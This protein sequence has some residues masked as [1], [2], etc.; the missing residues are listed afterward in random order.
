MFVD[1][2]I[3]GSVALSHLQPEEKTQ[4]VTEQSVRSLNFSENNISQYQLEQAINI[5]RYNP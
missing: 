2:V 4:F 5:V 1:I 3:A